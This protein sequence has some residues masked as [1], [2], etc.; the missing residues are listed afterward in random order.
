MTVRAANVVSITNNNVPSPDEKVKASAT[1]PVSGFLDEKVK[2]SVEVDN[3]KLQLVWDEETPDNY[4]SYMKK[5][6]AKGW[7]FPLPR[8]IVP[9]WEDMEVLDTEQLILY[10]SYTVDG[11]LQLDWTLVII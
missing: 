3:D 1:D 10:N 11:N 5:A 8:D 4:R 2:N 7:Y 9:T 6:W